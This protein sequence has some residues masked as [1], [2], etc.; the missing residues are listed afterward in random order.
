MEPDAA[1]RQT[2]N[3]EPLSARPVGRSVGRPG[4][5]LSIL[6][7]LL[8]GGGV[9]FMRLGREFVP[10]LQEGT[11]N[12]YAYM[13]PNV[14]LEE[15]KAVCSQISKTASG[16]PEIKNVSRSRRSIAVVVGFV[17]SVDRDTEIVC[18]LFGQTSQLGVQV[19]EMESRD[20]LTVCLPSQA[21]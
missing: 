19:R 12:C 14:S 10:T 8:I 18:L 1:P 13:N 5:L 20:F 9:G 3:V 6:L 11:I 4:A 7:V 17:R 2:V 21:A 15:I 16:I